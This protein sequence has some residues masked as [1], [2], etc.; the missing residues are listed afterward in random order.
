MRKTIIA[1]ATLIFTF[2]G[3]SAGVALV[4]IYQM[5]HLGKAVALETAVLASPAL[6]KNPGA[7]I[8]NGDVIGIVSIPTINE[9]YPIIQGTDSNDLK[10]GVGH[11][12]QSVMPGVKD[13]SVLSGH[14]DSVF[15]KL[16]ELKIG[17]QVIV[18]T[19][20]GIFTYSVFHTR[21][22]LPN[23]RTVIVPTPS[24]VLTLTTCYPFIYF[25]NA[26]KRFIVSAHL[27]SSV[28]T[29]L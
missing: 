19:R 24:A 3:V 25:G 26:P 1:L 14:R 27:V 23:D 17:S 15:S 22:V 18:K 8:K 6:Q 20:D 28:L 13:N 10:R 21:I 7:L 12:I 4:Q 16:G 11:F 9:V 29:T 2:G 5:D